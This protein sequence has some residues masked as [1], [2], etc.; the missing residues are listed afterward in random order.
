MRTALFIA[1]AGL[2]LV[3]CSADRSADERA[4]P[5]PRSVAG[6]NSAPITVSP[7]VNAPATGRVSRVNTDGGFVILS[8]PMGKLPPVGKKL[9]VYRAGMKVG[10]LKVSEPQYQHNTAADITAGEAHVGD[11]A[12][13]N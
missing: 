11:E 6:T 7:A 2:T 12:R 9:G 8:Y 10:E 13:E 5:A 1:A 4:S 3:G